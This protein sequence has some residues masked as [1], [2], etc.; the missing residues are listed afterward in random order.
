MNP[1]RY[2][3]TTRYCWMWNRQRR[4]GGGGKYCWTGSW[5]IRSCYIPDSNTKFD[6]RLFTVLSRYNSRK[7]TFVQIL[8]SQLMNMF[9]HQ[10]W[11][12]KWIFWIVIF[13]SYTFEPDCTRLSY[14]FRRIPKLRFNKVTNL[15]IG[16][17]FSKSRG[18]R[19]M[20]QTSWK[21]PQFQKVIKY[22]T[23][24]FRMTLIAKM[25]SLIYST[26]HFSLITNQVMI[27]IN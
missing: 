26:F 25:N 23:L 17:H 8:F 20:R 11:M 4:R 19:N 16:N 9:W 24:E 18:I 21:V 1:Y 15:V 2:L 6:F 27:I 5:R 22:A 3:Y 10:G 14:N 13:G 7:C 12:R